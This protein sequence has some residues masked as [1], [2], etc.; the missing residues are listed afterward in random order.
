M[1]G[2]G[3]TEMILVGLVALMLF[4][5]RELPSLIKTLAGIY[6][7]IRRTAE[8][9]RAQ[10]MEADELREPIEE[11]RAAYHGTKAELDGAR[12]V[13]RRELQRARME[14][15]KAQ[16]KIN[17][18]AR[19]EAKRPPVPGDMLAGTGPSTQV[20]SA[21]QA[22]A[23]ASA[24][25]AAA[26]AATAAASA[27]TAA[28]AASSAAAEAPTATAS[29]VAA[30][31]APRAVPAA[32]TVSTVAAEAAPRA[33][34]VAGTVSSAPPEAVPR[35]VPVPGAVPVEPASRVAA[36]GRPVNERDVA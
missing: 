32:A 8:Q 20:S 26:S 10:V 5:P 24:A 21:S 4:S 11:I 12:D 29:T 1:F 25:T 36:P 22:V 30:E 17:E 16:Q 19:E 34:P 23:A 35:A 6:G 33:V 2:I 27:A 14:V 31:A 28:A 15:V 18:I 7:S 13:A 3:I 9:F